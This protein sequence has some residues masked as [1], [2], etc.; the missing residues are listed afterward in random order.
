[1][2][3]SEEREHLERTKKNLREH[4]VGQ[5]AAIDQIIQTLQKTYLKLPAS[6]RPAAS[7]FFVGPSGVGK[8]ELAKRLA[9]E[10]TFDD[11][12][13]I[14]LDMSEFSEGHGTSKLLGSPA[15]RKST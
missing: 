3:L 12:A 15:D 11:R 9:K 2:L 5:D 8:T 4:I 14:R 6:K 13:L 10:L 1:M 7:L